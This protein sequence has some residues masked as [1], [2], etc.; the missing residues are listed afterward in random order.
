MSGKKLVIGFAILMA[1]VMGLQSDVFAGGKKKPQKFKV[2]IENIGDPNGLAAA[3]GSRYPFALSPGFYLVS[4][5]NI[6]LFTEGKKATKAL[7]AQAE[8]G[9]PKMLL[10]EALHSAGAGIGGIF[11]RPVGVDGQAPILPGG[12]YHF[13][14]SATP[15]MKLNFAAMFG[16]SNDLFYAPASGIELFVKGQPLTGDVTDKLMLWDAGTEVNQAPGIGAD[17]APRQ[18]SPNMGSD[19][20]GRV[21]KV[22][23]GYSYPN[24]REVLRVTITQE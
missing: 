1:L 24:V 15:G 4:K 11:N 10:T 2:V 5:R 9:N 16:Q 12:S 21:G 23:D 8:D 14:F 6:A 13:T 19:E 7:E 3:D 22:A 17:Q 20:N 18:K